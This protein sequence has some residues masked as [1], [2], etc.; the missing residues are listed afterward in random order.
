MQIDIDALNGLFT[1][2]QGGQWLLGLVLGSIVLVSFARWAAG[3][4]NSTRF[5]KWLRTRWGGWTLNL[6]AS[7]QVTF[8]AAAK[9]GTLTWLSALQSLTVGVLVALANAGV[10]E[11]GK[12]SSPQPPQQ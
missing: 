3:R 2:L 7:L 5:A 9:A 11:L 12:D 10:I 1:A 4:W 6:I 8:M